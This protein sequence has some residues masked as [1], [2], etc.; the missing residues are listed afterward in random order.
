MQQRKFLIGSCIRPAKS[1]TMERRKKGHS[2]AGHVVLSTA[3][4][5]S[6]KLPHWK[7]TSGLVRPR[8]YNYGKRACNSHSPCSAMWIQTI[9]EN[10]ERGHVTSS[11]LWIQ[12]V[13][14]FRTRFWTSGYSVVTA[15]NFSHLPYNYGN[16]A[17]IFREWELH[18]LSPYSYKPLVWPS[19]L[20]NV[21]LSITK[22]HIPQCTANCPLSF[23]T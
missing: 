2:V 16:I 6:T 15:T 18:G 17:H 7:K 23:C 8:A 14:K 12:T 11:F 20:T 1:N 3:L 5:N 21:L 13:T 4:T 22:Y 19:A 10:M 9:T